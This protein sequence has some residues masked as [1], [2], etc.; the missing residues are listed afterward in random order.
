MAT[1]SNLLLPWFNC[2]TTTISF[3]VSVVFDHAAEPGSLKHSHV[4][5]ENF[6]V[7]NTVGGKG[8]TCVH[9]QPVSVVCCLGART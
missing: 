5:T 6:C 1:D 3:R 7:S 8:L 4:K 9:P 2:S